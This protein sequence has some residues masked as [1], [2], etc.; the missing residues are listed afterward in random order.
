VNVLFGDIFKAWDRLAVALFR[1][2]P[3]KLD[4]TRRWRN[5]FLDAVRF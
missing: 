4:Q 1:T 5:R 2:Y 3:H